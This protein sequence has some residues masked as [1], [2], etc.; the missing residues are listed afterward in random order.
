MLLPLVGGAGEEAVSQ[1]EG[2]APQ[3]ATYP[4][5]HTQPDAADDHQHTHMPATDLERSLDSYTVPEVAM[6]DQQARPVSLR[7]LL[8]T[9]QPVLLNFIFTTCTAICPVMSATFAQVQKKLGRD[10][11]HVRMVSISIDPEHDTP[12]VLASYAER[13]HAGS[14]WRFLTGSLE[15]SIA[16]QKAFEAYRG[17]KMNHVPLTL[18]HAPAA[19]QWVRYEGFVKADDLVSETRLML[20]HEPRAGRE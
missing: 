14:Q 9:D 12:A 2:Y 11:R 5:E 16:T 7:A 20:A 8:N 17:D 1:G 10:A 13:F 15:N 18:L 3:Q 6:L 19:A 4:Q